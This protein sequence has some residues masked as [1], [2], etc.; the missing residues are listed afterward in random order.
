MS[1]GVYKVTVTL[2]VYLQDESAE[3][4]RSRVAAMSL[5]ELHETTDEGD[6]VGGK[7]QIVTVEYVAEEE[8]AEFLES[9]GSDGD[10]FGGLENEGIE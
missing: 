7:M 2:D 4:A 5:S 1:D 3:A 9:V 10:F 8:V 6:M